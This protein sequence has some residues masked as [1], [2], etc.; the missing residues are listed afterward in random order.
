M[1]NIVLLYL[2]I[3][4]IVAFLLYGVDKLK[5]KKGK[6]RVRERLLLGMAVVG[7]SL[8]ALL[9]VKVWHHKTMH[10]KFRFGMPVIVVIQLVCVCLFL[11]KYR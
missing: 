5:A 1:L 2:L 11:A 3:V 4:N 7:G 8:G 9:G 6:W 10:K